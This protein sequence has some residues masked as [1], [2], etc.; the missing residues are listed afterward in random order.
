M[1]IRSSRMTRPRAVAQFAILAQLLPMTAVP[2]RMQAQNAG[3]ETVRQVERFRG[4]ARLN[5][6]AARSKNAN[7]TVRQVSIPGKQRLDV[8]LDPGFR[9]VTLRAGKVTATIDGKEEKHDTGD[10]WSVK[11][12][13]RMTVMATGETAVLEVMSLVVR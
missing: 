5:D 3:E 12:N 6:G 1:Q 11:E 7:V 10:I 4:S 9:V 13:A 8:P 2:G